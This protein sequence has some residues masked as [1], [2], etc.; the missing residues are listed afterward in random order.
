MVISHISEEIQVGEETSYGTEASSYDKNFG[1]IQSFSYSENEAIE[2]VGSVGS[3]FTFQKNEPGIY[4]VTGSLVTRVSKTTLPIALKAFFGELS[5]GAEDY[6]INPVKEVI[7]HSVKAQHST[8]ELVTLTG[9]VFTNLSI[10]A[11]KDGFM[12][13][14]LDYFAKK[15]I[16]STATITTTLPSDS[17]FS[18]L[19]ISGSYDG[20]N[21]KANNFNLTFDWNM[22][23]NDG[24]GLESV[25]AGERRLIQRAVKNN[26]TI[27]GNFEA[28]IENTNELGYTDEK[29]E[30][31]LILTSSRGTDN[32]HVFTLSGCD[33]DNKNTEMSSEAG[34]KT[35]S[36]DI[37]ARSVVFTGDE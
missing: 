31:T 26:L 11:S 37:L 14:S 4:S 8:T 15:L 32:E 34:M 12:E 6:T 28:L 29:T 10:D 33:L 2:Q 25:S 13:L 9:V 24:R 36:A 21:I 23:A 19:D 20:N 35:I 30:K 16:V 17:M 27:S 18:W 7:S 22:D 3:G 5:S 1:Y